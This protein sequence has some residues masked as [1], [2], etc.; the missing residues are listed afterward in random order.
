[1]RKIIKV[2]G[3]F[4]LFKYIYW[5]IINVLTSVLKQLKTT[6]FKDFLPEYFCG[7][8]VLSPKIVVWC[9]ND[10]SSQKKFL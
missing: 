7:A 5:N 10:D 4:F 8:I 6:S 9:E 2:S 1:M 3:I